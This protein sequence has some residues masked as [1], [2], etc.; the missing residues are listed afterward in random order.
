MRSHASLAVAALLIAF[1]AADA[2]AGGGP[3][4]IDHRL[5]YDDSGIWN[6]SVQVAVV[7]GTVAGV[8]GGALWLG[9]DDKLGDT[10]WRSVDAIALTAVTTT[11][12]KYAFSRKRPSQTDDPN[13]FFAGHGYQSFPSG[14][15]AAI[16]AA[17]TPIMVAYGP[18][19]PLVYGLAALPLYDAVARMKT[20][21][22]WQSDVLVGAAIG[23][24]FGIYAARRDSPI[25]VGW[26]P[27]GVSVGFSKQF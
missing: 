25:V 6:R 11:T 16:A 8:V 4:G 10:L 9:D 5:T 14:E 13:E 26:L 15:V 7:T 21:G 2:A 23:T 1:H 3:F 12:A 19:H 20:Q 17:T 22:H 27:G 18:D 24:G